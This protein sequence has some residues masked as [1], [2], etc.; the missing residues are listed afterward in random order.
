MEKL[1]SE[2]ETSDPHSNSTHSILQYSPFL[3]SLSSE[4]W[5]QSVGWDFPLRS[6]ALS[7]FQ[8]SVRVVDGSGYSVTTTNDACLPFGNV[9]ANK[10][11]RALPAPS[12]T[13]DRTTGSSGSCVIHVRRILTC[14]VF[15][16]DLARFNRFRQQNRRREE[17]VGHDSCSLTPQ[18][19]M[20]PSYLERLFLPA[21][22]PSIG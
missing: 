7:T 8:V 14:S 2:C 10:E 16:C 6:L 5:W 22:I 15:D 4:R 18:F 13:T 3:S 19:P 17:R 9:A 12:S 11:G 21:H 1:N 20:V